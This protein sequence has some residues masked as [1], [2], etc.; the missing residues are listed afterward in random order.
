VGLGLLFQIL[1]LRWGF[2]HFLKIFCHH[3]VN[4]N[5]FELSNRSKIF[6][7]LYL[8]FTVNPWHLHNNIYYASGRIRRIHVMS[9]A[10]CKIYGGTLAKLITQ[11]ERIVLQTF[12]LANTGKITDNLQ[13]KKKKR[14]FKYWINVSYFRFGRSK[15]VW[16][17]QTSFVNI[18]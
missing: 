8:S 11:E 14:N 9:K 13:F 5:F 6:Q 17:T 10:V 18:L 1:L 16:L 3:V 15:S 7:N 2:C 4:P 12:G